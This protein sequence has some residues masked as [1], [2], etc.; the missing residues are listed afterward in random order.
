MY[1][2]LEIYKQNGLQV[3]KFQKYVPS[4]STV[5]KSVTDIHII[6]HSDI[7]REVLVNLNLEKVVTKWKS[8]A[9]WFLQ[10][11]TISRELFVIY[12]AGE[13]LTDSSF[14]QWLLCIDCRGI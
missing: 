11:G 2:T 14:G 10:Q 9:C 6:P 5:Q 3:F 1:I 7:K 12:Q 8:D 13:L 4:C